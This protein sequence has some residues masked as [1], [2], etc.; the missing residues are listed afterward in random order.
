MNGQIIF[1][2]KLNE[3]VSN[4]DNYYENINEQIQYSARKRKRFKLKQM[5][6]S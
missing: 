5:K 6:A 3:F 4:S 1:L 2:F